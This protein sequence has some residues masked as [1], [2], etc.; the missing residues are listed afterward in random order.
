MS[1]I[2]YE[3]MYIDNELELDEAIAACHKVFNELDVGADDFSYYYDM[4]YSL[5]HFAAIRYMR[6]QGYSIKDNEFV[7]LY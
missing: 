1:R 5:Y 6:S 7:K 2:N 4:L 3:K